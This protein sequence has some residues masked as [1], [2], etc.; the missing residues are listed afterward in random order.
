MYIY[1][2]RV[3]RGHDWT[4]HLRVRSSRYGEAVD[5]TVVVDP[6]ASISGRKKG[7]DRHTRPC[8]VLRVFRS[9]MLLQLRDQA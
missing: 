4:V 3:Y 7:Y 8:V 1:T 2:D 6:Y 5:S 9:W